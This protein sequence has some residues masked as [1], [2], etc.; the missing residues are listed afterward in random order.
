MEKDE[1]KQYLKDNLKIDIEYRSF[2]PKLVLKLDN[3]IIS[4]ISL[5]KII[6]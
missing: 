5:S 1:I 2:M 6:L 4:S 3:E